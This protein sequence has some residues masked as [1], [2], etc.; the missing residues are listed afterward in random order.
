M[1]SARK[2][3]SEMTLSGRSWGFLALFNHL[4]CPISGSKVAVLLWVSSPLQVAFP[5]VS[6][7]RLQP[8]S[9]QRA[10]LGAWETHAI[11]EACR[12]CI[13]SPILPSTSP[14][15]EETPSGSKKQDTQ[16]KTRKTPLS[17][18]CSHA[19]FP[20]LLISLLFCFLYRQ[21][22]PYGLG[23]GYQYFWQSRGQAHPAIVIQLCL[24][25][26]SVLRT[27]FFSQPLWP[28]PKRRQKISVIIINSSNYI[29]RQI[30][31]LS[32]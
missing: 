26:V 28:W 31:I 24:L 14:G 15:D 29:L 12:S 9:S 17:A 10:T 1:V 20:L 18:S 2:S 13:V 4:S 21:P 19:R 30:F 11:W 32:E 25:A 22:M 3:H 8:I 16:S 5:G 6:F 23:V 7:S 27:L